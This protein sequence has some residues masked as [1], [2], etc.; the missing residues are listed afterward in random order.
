[1]SEFDALPMYEPVVMPVCSDCGKFVEF[2][3]EAPG[4]SKDYP[5]YP[6]G[7]VVGRC[8]CAKERVMMTQQYQRFEALN[9][10]IPLTM[11]LA[12]IDPRFV[13]EMK[14][15]PK[16]EEVDE[17]IRTRKMFDV[18]IREEFGDSSE[19]DKNDLLVKVRSMRMLKEI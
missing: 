5:D 9:N 8:G 12:G 1:M 3:G 16:I 17:T 7:V 15:Y 4:R 6:V 18:I 11:V 19:L 14:G 10:T 13:F 2:V